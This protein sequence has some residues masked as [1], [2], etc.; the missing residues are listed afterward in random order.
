LKLAIFG[1]GYVGCVTAACFARDGYHVIGVDVKPEKIENIRQGKSPII[2]PGLAELIGAGVAQNCLEA[3]DDTTYAVTEADVIMVCVGTPSQ[4]NGSLDLTYVE[5][6]CQDIGRALRKQSS[7]KVVVIRSTV[8]P[9][10]IVTK[11]LPLLEQEAGKIA[12]HDFGFC[13]NPEFLREGSA[14]KDFDFPPFTVIGELD[15]R[16]GE[17][18]ARVYA[19]IDAPLYR[20]PLGTAEMVKYA[21]NAFHALKVVFANEIGNLCQEYGVDSHQVMDIF[22]QDVKLN[23]SP[24]YLKPGFAFGGSCLPKDLR[25][26]L[27]AARQVD[28]QL[29]VLEAILPSNE[30]QAQKALE[31]LIDSGMRKVGLIGLSFKPNTDDLRESPAIELA[32]RLIGKGFDL[33][34]YDH[35]VSLS[36]LHGSN[37]AYIDQVIPHIGLLMQSSLEDTVRQSEAVVVTKQPSPTEYER[38]VS[39]LQPEQVL[40]D[41]VRLNGV[42]IP[43]FEGNYYGICW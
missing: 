21:S 42:P 1:L 17:Q 10:S 38:L 2:E 35:E 13:V 8:L 37:R 32:E 22:V 39:L 41:L 20:V 18:L 25:A 15:N 26:L 31:M 43:Q 4:K 11:I 33:F 27:Y 12:G 19:A 30:L 40:I 16:S 7:Y 29:P 5:N 3:T 24:Y 34:I 28:I 6:V 36:H 9:G 14:I 23:L